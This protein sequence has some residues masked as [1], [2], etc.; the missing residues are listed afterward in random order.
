MNSFTLRTAELTDIPAITEL[1]LA[2]LEEDFGGLQPEQ[3]KQIS[4]QLPNYF[5]AHLNKDCFVYVAIDEENTIIGQAILYIMEKPANPFFPSGKSGTVLSVYTKPECRR[6][7]VATW[8][9]KLLMVD[10]KRMELDLLQLS[11]TEQGRDV[12]TRLGFRPVQDRY[13]SMEYILIGK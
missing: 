2:Y 9:M 13:L 3:R 1:R 8:L 5:R 4:D 7:R 10:A 11:A 6:N 12:Y